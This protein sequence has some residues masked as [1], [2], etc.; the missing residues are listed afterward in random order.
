M[1]VVVVVGMQVGEVQGRQCQ[2]ALQDE[3]EGETQAWDVG[4]PAL[5]RFGVDG[6]GGAGVEGPV[7]EEGEGGDVEGGGGVWIG[8]VDCVEAEA[9]E[10]G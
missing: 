3:V 8:G 4:A 9:A 1:V 6:E 5:L 10:A 2:E 7:V